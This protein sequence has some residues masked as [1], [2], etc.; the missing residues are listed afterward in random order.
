MKQWTILFCLLI[1][2]CANA[3]KTTTRSLVTIQSFAQPLVIQSS[4]PNVS[5]V[6][7]ELF[8]WFEDDPS[9]VSFNLYYGF[10]PTGYD[11]AITGITDLS[12]VVS[13]MVPGTTYYV[14]A[15]AVDK[16]GN[17]S[18]FSQQLTFVMPTTLEMGFTFDESVTNVSVLSS[19]NLM[20]WQPS[21]ARPRT[22]GLWRVDVDS[23]N[24]VEYYRGI[25]QAI[26][27]L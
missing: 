18:D 15:T 6:D 13:N 8:E 2:G 24:P 9:A 14:A 19:T 26:P 12:E 20:T 23:S 21:N 25:G 17:E 1:T 10:S 27:A 3:P 22:N 11:H 5:I 7:Y 16:D 4:T